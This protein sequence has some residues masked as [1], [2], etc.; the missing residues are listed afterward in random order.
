MYSICTRFHVCRWESLGILDMS[1]HVQHRMTRHESLNQ[2][3]IVKCIEVKGQSAQWLSRS[4]SE[5]MTVW[6][7]KAWQRYE[8]LSM[9][10]NT[11]WSFWPVPLPASLFLGFLLPSC[12]TYWKIFTVMWCK[13]LLLFAPSQYTVNLYFKQKEFKMTLY[14]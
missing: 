14:Y 6:K 9:N 2:Q 1:G 3:G 12:C 4:H 13:C 5:R 8:T 7:P 10:S 11:L